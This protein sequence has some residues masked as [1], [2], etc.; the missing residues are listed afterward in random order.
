MFSI[1]WSVRSWT[2]NSFLRCFIQFSNLRRHCS[3]PVS[4]NF[5]VPMISKGHVI[6][7]LK[8]K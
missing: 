6:N 8:V 3:N 1:V 5:K 2:G 7:V 4:Q